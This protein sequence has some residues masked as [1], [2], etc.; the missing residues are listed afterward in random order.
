MGTATRG[1]GPV[2][3]LFSAEANRRSVAL[4]ATR[5]WGSS[6]VQAELAENGPHLAHLLFRLRPV[7]SATVLLLIHL[8][9]WRSPSSSR[10]AGARSSRAMVR[11]SVLNDALR[12]IF[13]AEKRG[14]RQVLVRPASK[15]IIK[16]LQQMMKHGAAARAS[17][18]LR[19]PARALI[20]LRPLAR[21]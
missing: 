12:S 13:N 20:S 2:C 19:A 4:L 21:L 8:R 10:Q 14:K 9:V 6:C 1:T 5:V 16:F 7:L 15:V 3:Q 11:M 18:Y 17:A